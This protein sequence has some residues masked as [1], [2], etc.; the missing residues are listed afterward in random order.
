MDTWN[1][2]LMVLPFQTWSED[3]SKK[4]EKELSSAHGSK[5]SAISMQCYCIVFPFYI[6][7]RM[8]VPSKGGVSTLFGLIGFLAL[9]GMKCGCIC[10]LPF[11][12][13][14][15]FW[16]LGS[17]FLIPEKKRHAYVNYALTLVYV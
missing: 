7:L 6:H 4:H 14:R 9:C 10:T 16:A 3:V 2:I 11:A 17:P 8:E 5:T 12:V 15:C 13:F 1:Y